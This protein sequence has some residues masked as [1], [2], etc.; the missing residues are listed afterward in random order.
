VTWQDMEIRSLSQSADALV[1]LAGLGIPFRALWSRIPGIEKSDVDE[2]AQ[3]A[4]DGD[5]I[6][7]MQLE[8]ERQ[9]SGNSADA[10][11]DE[12]QAA[13]SADVN[14]VASL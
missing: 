13:R 6:R 8:L 4:A 2:W 9:Y 5:P 14:P 1:K 12:P 7:R 11:L 3:M 10:G